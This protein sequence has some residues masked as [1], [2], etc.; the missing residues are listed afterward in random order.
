M[1]KKNKILLAALIVIIISLG[2]LRDYVFV[3]INKITGQGLQGEGKLFLLKWPLTFLFSLVY[4]GIF[5]LLIH[6]IFSKKKYLQLTVLIYLLLFFISFITAATGYLFFS[7]EKVY[8]FIRTIMGITQSPIVAM[9][10]VPAF[11]W[12]EFLAVEKK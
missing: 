8:P 1:H 9:I 12:N 7:M 11:L 10:L 2:Y 5:C 3:S 6:Y 4:L